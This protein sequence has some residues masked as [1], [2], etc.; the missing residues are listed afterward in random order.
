MRFC[1]IVCCEVVFIAVNGARPPL[2]CIVNKGPTK[3]RERECAG[4]CMG[5]FMSG[6]HSVVRLCKSTD[7]H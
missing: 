2:Q 4:A 1:C 5:V 6:L 7:W 3:V